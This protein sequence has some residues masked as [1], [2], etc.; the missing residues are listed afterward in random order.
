MFCAPAQSASLIS[1]LTCSNG[2]LVL[3]PFPPTKIQLSLNPSVLITEL[4]R[5]EI[6]CRASSLSLRNRGRAMCEDVHREEN[7]ETP[8]AA[9]VL[10]CW[11]VEC[12]HHHDGP[13]LNLLQEF[14]QRHHICSK[15]KC[16]IMYTMPEIFDLNFVFKGKYSPPAHISKEA[17]F[18]SVPVFP[19]VGRT[20]QTTRMKTSNK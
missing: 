5:S 19:V 4:P 8:E 15:R 2:V 17:V 6:S 1:L 9:K 16:S 14:D 20:M 11:I 12:S 10:C 7:S 3:M 18:T 13:V